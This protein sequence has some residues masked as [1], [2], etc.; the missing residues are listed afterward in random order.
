MDVISDT[1]RVVRLTGAIFLHAR[2]TA[3][4]AI[5]TTSSAEMADYLRL[6]SD[7]IAIFHILVEGQGWF[8]VS[9]YAPLQLRAGDA[10]LLPHNPPHVMSSGHGT[11]PMPMLSVLPPLPPEGFVE[12]NARGAGETSQFLCGFLHCDQRFNPLLGAL[13]E[14]MLVRSSEGERIVETIASASSAA[15][16]A[17]AILTMQP[18]EWLATTLQHTVEE[19]LGER[20]GNANMLARLSE[21]LFVEIVRRY[22]QQLP[23]SS[24]GWLAGLRDPIVGQ[25]LRLMH[26]HPE[27]AWTVEELALTVAVS[28][29]TLA[30]RFT[31]LIGETP[32]RYLA[33]W[34]IHLAQSLL[35][36]TTLNLGQVAARVGYD[37]DVAFNRAFKRHV[38]QPPAAWRAT[39]GDAL[40]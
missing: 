14:M 24:G 27:R 12:V 5:A 37:S 32:M 28:R 3:P 2:L 26:A 11:A 33:T 6:P 20:P 17:P 38:G 8:A 34:R 16:V 40:S 25:S 10:I 13:P 15:S 30:Q 4:W 35:K 36:Q 18:G 7:C 29:S 22:M 39:A 19:S 1:L 21:I 23:M 31:T 9:G